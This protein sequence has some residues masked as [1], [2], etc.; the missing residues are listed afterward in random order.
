MTSTIQLPE[1]E[2]IANFF[3]DLF[4]MKITAESSDFDD[5]SLVLFA[6]YIDNNKMPRNFIACDIACAAVFG[7][8]LTG[9]PPA[10]VEAAINTEVLP[11]NLFD[12]MKE[13]LNIAVNLFPLSNQQRIVIEK[14]SQDEEAF[15]D[16]KSCEGAPEVRIKFSV[17]RL[18]DGLMVIGTSL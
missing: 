8:A 17:P 6:D 14:I 15:N 12:N 1:I 16:Y 9:F 10:Q 5:S 2:G 7:A 18:G 3:G 13:I 4:D 11:E